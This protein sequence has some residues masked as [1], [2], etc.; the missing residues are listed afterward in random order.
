MGRDDKQ[1]KVKFETLRRNYTCDKN[2]LKK[3]GSGRPNTKIYDDEMSQLWD[4]RKKF[5]VPID[6]G[7]DTTKVSINSSNDDLD[8]IP[9]DEEQAI[10]AVENNSVCKIY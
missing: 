6:H 3:S 8:I 9:V 1:I 2:V 5:T 10:V 4:Q 7:F